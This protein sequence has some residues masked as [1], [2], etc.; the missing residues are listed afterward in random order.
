MNIHQA[1]LCVPSHLVRGGRQSEFRP[2]R[3]AATRT[4]LNRKPKN[5][6]NEEE[7]PVTFRSRIKVAVFSPKRQS[8]ESPLGEKVK[9]V[10]LN[11][12]RASL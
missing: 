4:F 3:T 7:T 10:L 2:E 12:V 1:S 11:N 6:T 8:N 9:T 5:Q